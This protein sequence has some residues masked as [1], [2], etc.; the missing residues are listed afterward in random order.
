[1]IMIT[2]SLIYFETLPLYSKIYGPPD[3]MVTMYISRF[4]KIYAFHCM[5]SINVEIFIKFKKALKVNFKTRIAFYHVYNFLVSIICTIFGR[6]EGDD[7]LS[8]YPLGRIIYSVYMT[9]ICIM[10][11]SLICYLYSKFSSRLKS[12]DMISLVVLTLISVI[13]VI[14]QVAT[15]LLMSGDI[16]SDPGL[17]FFSYL[18]N[19]LEGVIE[20]IVFNFSTVMKSYFKDFLFLAFPLKRRKRRLSSRL[21]NI[22]L[23]MLAKDVQDYR[24]SEESLNFFSD[25]FDNLTTCVSFKQTLI[26]LFVSA[27]LRFSKDVEK[28]DFEFKQEDIN[29]LYSDTQLDF[30]LSS[31]FK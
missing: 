5:A 27:T 14:I 1:M 13:I 17:N 20:F 8:F 22:S 19:S 31:K 12:K 30:I 24:L 3:I 26:K 28:K 23:S 16:A 21:G 10:L 11:V 25:V 7:F 6:Y 29:D 2:V 4:A 18:L 15:T 9:L